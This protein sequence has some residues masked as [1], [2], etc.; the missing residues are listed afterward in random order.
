MRRSCERASWWM[1]LALTLG[2]SDESGD[3]ARGSTAG[4]AGDVGDPAGAVAVP[5]SGSTP[6]AQVSPPGTPTQAVTTPTP[7]PQ[8]PSTPMPTPSSTEQGGAGGAGT[9]ATMAEG[10]GGVLGAVGGMSGVGAGGAAGSDAGSGGV[11]GAGAGGAGGA[12]SGSAGAGGSNA[13]GVGGATAGTGGA[14]AGG[15]ETGGAGGMGS[16]SVHPDDA[17]E[18]EGHWYRLTMAEIG[19]AEAEAI[20]EEQGGYLACVASES[21]D[22]FVFSLAGTTRPWIG[23]N[24]EDDVNTWVWVNGM[25]VTYT[26][27]QPGQPDAPSTERWVKVAE[28]GTWD[29]GNIPTSYICEWDD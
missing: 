4:T 17:V 10:S 1:F 8:M 3:S 6:G 12:V 9:I 25:P 2:C 14:A 27:W 20:C 15:A 22:A 21:E 24:N 23:L 18:F 28:D 16:V 13:G 7:T 29:D 19:G 5:G 11:G 26:H